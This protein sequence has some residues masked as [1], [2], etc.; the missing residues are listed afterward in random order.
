MKMAVAVTGASGVA[1]GVRLME[2]LDE[3][4]VDYVCMVSEAA[5][6][7][8]SYELGGW[9]GRCMDE[10]RL[11]GEVASGSARFDAMVI[12]PC[13]MKTLSAV[14][15]GYASNII[16]RAA[17]VMIKEGK[18]L[19]LVP[20]ETPL[21]QIH[22]ENMLRLSKMGVVILPAMPGF[23]H[24]PETV[25]DMVDFIVGKVLDSLGIDND[26]YRRWRPGI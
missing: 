10:D 7:V 4:G 9:K 23:Y 26:L 15:N 17:D 6:K 5:K 1:Y 16:T 12:I 20:R 21:S 24:R 13:S 2:A 3:M 19:V 8:A 22:L 25:E 11:D 18:K 14:A